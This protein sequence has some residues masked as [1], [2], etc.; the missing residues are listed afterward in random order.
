MDKF[1]EE[2]SE[3]LRSFKKTLMQGKCFEA[4]EL[5][6]VLSE[7]ETREFSISSPRIRWYCSA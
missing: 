4:L 3:K 5:R 2:F 1:R 6:Y 7:L